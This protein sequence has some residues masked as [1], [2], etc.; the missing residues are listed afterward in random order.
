M[1]PTDPILLQ[2][3][4]TTRVNKDVCDKFS[5]SPGMLNA[6]VIAYIVE[7]D[8]NYFFIRDIAVGMGMD[9]P[10]YAYEMVSKLKKK[11]LMSTHS[12]F[13]GGH[14]KNV[15]GRVLASKQPQEL[16]MEG[17]EVVRQ[18][19]LYMKHALEKGTPQIKQEWFDRRFTVESKQKYR[20]A[21]KKRYQ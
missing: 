4:Y 20:E 8:Q 18:Y 16:T 1:K 3:A 12:L 13:V 17:E 15:G 19:R 10:Q 5:I 14:A 7:A 6:L 21:K 11:G 9:N 2:G